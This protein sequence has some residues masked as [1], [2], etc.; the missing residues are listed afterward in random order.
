MEQVTFDKE[1]L[2][3]LIKQA[4][5]ESM[6]EEMFWIRMENLGTVS[7]EEMADI[8]GTYPKPASERDITSSDT[9]DI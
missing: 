6:K 4:V 7:D 8:E 5:K 1:E 2:Y 3:K 9:V